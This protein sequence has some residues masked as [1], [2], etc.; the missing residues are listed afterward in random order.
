MTDIDDFRT[1][2]VAQGELWE[3][4]KVEKLWF[5]IVNGMI[6]NG[7]M[8]DMG[9]MGW[10]VYCVVKSHANLNTGDSFPSIKRIAELIGVS[11]DTIQR[12]MNRLAELGFINADKSG[13][14]NR[15][16]IKESIPMTTSAGEIFG[17][18]EKQYIPTK[19]QEFV[20]ELE[21]FAK[22]GNI[23]ADKNITINVT[24]NVQNITQ[25]DGG[26]V[27]MNV[28]SVQVAGGDQ[29]T[30]ASDMQKIVSKLK[31]IE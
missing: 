7:H 2:Q 15:Y 22:S 12:A 1:K 4:L 24:F 9:V 20:T 25:R 10:A 30:G 27:T 19:F 5:H 14:H 21:H 31:F 11:H 26:N 17:Y 18:G 13:K 6:T 23:P 29:A 3:E 28:Q 16:T 8:K